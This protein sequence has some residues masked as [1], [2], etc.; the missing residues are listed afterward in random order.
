MSEIK[1]ENSNLRDSVDKLDQEKER[2]DLDFTDLQ[3]KIFQC[4]RQYKVLQKKYKQETHDLKKEVEVLTKGR[5]LA[6]EKAVRQYKA[7]AE[8]HKVMKRE[9]NQIRRRDAEIVEMLDLD[10]IEL[11][12]DRLPFFNDKE[13]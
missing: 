11:L 2:T 5:D 6:I 13:K 10:E 1:L 9:I 12:T 8:E 4:E 3:E 7:V